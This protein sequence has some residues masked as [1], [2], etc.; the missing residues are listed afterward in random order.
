MCGLAVVVTLPGARVEPTMLKTFDRLLAHRGP[1]GSGLAT[2]TRDA[3]PA[4]PDAAE[5][6]LV[7]RRLAIIDLD[8]RANQPMASPDGRHVLVFNGEIY[9]YVELRE[10]LIRLGHVFRTTSDSEVLIAAF[11]AWGPAALSRFTGMFAFVLLDR[12]KREL[13][14]ARDPFGIKPL[15]W[16]LG[17]NCIALAS[18]IP[19]LL[20]VPGVGRAADLARARLFLAVGQTDAGERTMFAAVR[21]LPAGTFATISLARPVAPSPVAYWQPRIAPEPHP[22]PAAAGELR[23]LFLDSIRLHLRSDVPLGIALSGGVDSS[24]I[25]A[26]ARAVG[27]KDLAIRT[28]SFVAEGSDVD[29][30]RFI[31]LAATSAG[32]QP[33][34]VRITPDEIVADIDDLVT[35]Q[36]EP[37]GSL[38]IYAQHRVMR[39]AAESGIKVMLDG[40]GADELFAGYRPYL[41][42]RLSELIARCQWGAALRLA[43]AMRALPGVT[44]GLLAQA[45]EPAVPGRLRA[46]ARALAGRPELPPW[47][48]GR[49]FAERG[50]MQTAAAPRWGRDFLHEALVQSLRETVLPALLRYEDRNA[51]RF[52]IESRVPFLTPR[53]AQFAYGQPSESLVDA[54]ATSKAVLRAAMRGLVPDAIL[55]R[56]DKIGFATP[57]RLWAQSLRPWFQRMLG[58]DAA[59]AIPW[60]KPAAALQTLERRIAQ[61]DP[62][63]FDL[64]RTVN[65]IH[66]AE[67]FGVAYG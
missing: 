27:G 35:A 13:F 2:F 10:E 18:E 48:D 23:D 60:L 66:W 45:L 3:A 41:A 39:L 40:Q 57:D 14:L 55:D 24:S 30:T 34:S 32:A 64:W 53:L 43:R 28:F 15:F 5:V 8:P 21:S 16:A 58:S 26:G 7:F 62:F 54:R 42:R 38:S 9:N 36:G 65:V 59:R 29:E 67:Q 50:L 63:G 19:P 46:F 11:A 52:S 22:R 49:W 4:D 31:G 25:L 1:D 33:V 61:A 37:F 51:M 6:A 44:A 20:E 47:I 12:H 56:R 17:E